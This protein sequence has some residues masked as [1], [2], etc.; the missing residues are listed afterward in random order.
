[1]SFETHKIQIRRKLSK[2]YEKLEAAKQ[3][4]TELEREA[5][6][7]SR[8]DVNVRELEY[9]L[10]VKMQRE[11]LRIELLKNSELVTIVDTWRMSLV[12][13]QHCNQSAILYRKP[14]EEHPELL[15]HY[16]LM[17]WRRFINWGIGHFP[18]QV[19]CPDH[20]LQD[21]PEEKYSDDHKA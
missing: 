21:I 9:I 17:G 19:L 20:S 12:T 13:C 14:Q 2:A 16:E 11:A 18:I 3:L 4:C 7:V 1:M 15:K 10:R 8:D 5:A 6:Q